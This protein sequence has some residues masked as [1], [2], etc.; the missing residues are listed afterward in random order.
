M[1]QTTEQVQEEKKKKEKKAQQSGDLRGILTE[2]QYAEYEKQLNVIAEKYKNTVTKAETTLAEVKERFKS[3]AKEN[4]AKLYEILKQPNDENVRLAN[5]TIRSHLIRD[6]KHYWTKEWI[7]DSL[8]TELKPEQQKGAAGSG[9][10]GAAGDTT[11]EDPVKAELKELKAQL[12]L[13]NETVT[14]LQKSQEKDRKRIATMS[15]QLEEKEKELSKVKTIPK[16]IKENFDEKLN[17]ITVIITGA[18]IQRI[19]EFS[20]SAHGL[21]DKVRMTLKIQDKG[22]GV[23]DSLK[24]IQS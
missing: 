20:K 8:P 14:T 6:L 11:E 9:A 15:Q 17:A 12:K 5:D 2:K 3:E 19:D 13:K 7:I 1:S 22:I 23:I 4:I 16:S 21:T 18:S 24:K 10:A